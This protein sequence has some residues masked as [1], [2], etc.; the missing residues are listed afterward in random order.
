M[1]YNNKVQEKMEVQIKE[2]MRNLS[3]QTRYVENVAKRVY[4]SSSTCTEVV[5]LAARVNATTNEITEK[6]SDIENLWLGLEGKS[7]AT[8]RRLKMVVTTSIIVCDVVKK[9]D[10]L[11]KVTSPII[12]DPEANMECRV[13]CTDIQIHLIA[14][15][16]ALRDYLE[17]YQKVFVE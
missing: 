13:F 8:A 6:L 9:F 16:V 15:L 11:V 10:S 2:L 7:S 17:M 4:E 5:E 1:A 14:A 12:A 3:A